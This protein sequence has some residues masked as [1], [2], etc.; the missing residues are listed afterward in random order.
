MAL[1]AI[2]A[3]AGSATWRNLELLIVSQIADAIL[4]IDVGGTKIEAALVTSEGELVS[5]RRIKTVPGGEAPGKGRRESGRELLQR[6]ANLAFEVIEL[7]GGMRPG[8]CGVGCGGPMEPRG[9]T[10]SPL[11][12]EAWSRFPLRAALTDLLKMP[13][14]I[15]NDAKA[16]ALAE[17]WLGAAA[18]LANYLAMVVSTGVGGGLVVDGRLLDGNSANAGHIGHVIVVPDGEPCRC[19]GQGCLEAHASGPSIRRTRGVEPEQ[20]ST[21]VMRDT[22]TLVGRAVAS[23]VNL[24][25]LQNVFVGGSVALGFGAHFFE[26]ANVELARYCRLS[27]ASGATISPVGLGERA[28]LLGAAAVA[29]MARDGSVGAIRSQV[30]LPT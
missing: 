29:L 6:M 9:A 4:A 27:F 12:I 14:A 28:P 19:G 23:V 8:V 30:I 7:S 5:R 24:L 18:G 17:G 2:C 15:D 25:D 3:A 20:A 1:A 11:N 22:G 16:L 21:A 13:V 26:A 10:V